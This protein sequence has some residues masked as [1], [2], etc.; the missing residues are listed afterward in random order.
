M[1]AVSKSISADS[2]YA[3]LIE[4]F[5][6]T[7]GTGT[8]SASTSGSASSSVAPTQSTVSK[9]SSSERAPSPSGSESSIAH[10]E[11]LPP[12]PAPTANT[13]TQQVSTTNTSQSTPNST[14][15]AA[16]QQQPQQPQPQPPAEL[17]RSLGQLSSPQDY[18]N[19]MKNYAHDPHTVFYLQS[20]WDTYY[21]PYYGPL[22]PPDLSSSTSTG[23][24]VAPNAANDTTSQSPAVPLLPP[25]EP[26]PNVRSIIDKLAEYV[27]R[28][29]EEFEQRVSQKGDP[30]FAFLSA[31]HEH[32]A[33]YRT[34][35]TAERDK[36]ERADAGRLRA[37]EEAIPV[38]KTPGGRPLL[39]ITAFEVTLSPAF[40]IRSKA[41][42]LPKS[43][44]KMF[45]DDEEDM[46]QI[47]VSA[48][49]NSTVV[50][51]PNT[52]ESQ[53]TIQIAHEDVAAETRLPTAP[54]ASTQPENFSLTID[55]D[56]V[57]IDGVHI[58]SSGS[59]A[60]AAPS[61]T[62]SSKNESCDDAETGSG[63][64]A[65]RRRK[66]AEFLAG[67]VGAPSPAVS[68]TS[69]EAGATDMFVDDE[70][71][72]AIAAAAAAAPAISDCTGA[73]AELHSTESNSNHDISSR[74]ELKRRKFHE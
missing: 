19:V 65:D 52:S 48:A 70:T 46:E 8:T 33:Y 51:V 63:R 50:S 13:S 3:K 4:K 36:R 55:I 6:S 22:P 67:L 28:N 61:P 49:S 21:A 62:L 29:G 11:P 68:A 7:Y 72:N 54:A 56:G 41:P 64:R 69:I 57:P 15:L 12:P 20:W 23:T 59:P 44:H 31:T 40:G 27:A 1:T 43:E 58:A 5:R 42:R 37:R 32:Y 10:S 34:R 24:A 66:A 35:V 53:N 26:P 16:P 71:S 30:R 47:P 73:S 18:A 45:A 25:V 9:G 14:S 39:P 74:T 2:P 17:M 60:P 38:L